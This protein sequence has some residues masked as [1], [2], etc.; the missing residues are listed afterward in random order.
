LKDNFSERQLLRERE[1]ERERERE[2][3]REI[4][5]ER[6][7][8]IERKR[9][10]QTDKETKT[11]RDGERFQSHGNIICYHLIRKNTKTIKLH[12][13]HSSGLI[14]VWIIRVSKV[15]MSVLKCYALTIC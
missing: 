5:R 4:G 13:I 9:D 7:R 1:K 15:P 3:W 6:E 8:E 10:R 11:E 14:V 2:I 12:S